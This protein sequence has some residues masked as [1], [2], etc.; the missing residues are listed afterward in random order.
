MRWTRSRFLRK[1]LEG[2]VLFENEVPLSASS[3][4]TALL[5][6][7]TLVLLTVLSSQGCDCGGRPL[8]EDPQDFEDAGEDGSTPSVDPDASVNPDDGSVL[9]ADGGMAEP[10]AGSGL[11]PDG[12]CPIVTCLGL[13]GPVRDFCT[14]QVLQCGGCGGGLVCDV[15]RH[16]CLQP[17]LNCAELG[18]ECGQV[19]N[20][21]GSRLNC[22]ACPDAG[23]ECNRNSHKCEPCSAPTCADLGYQCGDVWLGCGP[24]S[25]TTNCGTCG[26]D[27]VC[28]SALHICEPNCT[29]NTDAV[30]CAAAGANCGLI[31][32]G[33]GGQASCG[34]CTGGLVCGARGIGN[35]CEL[36][37]YPSEC[38]A[39]NRVCGPLTS[40]CGGA[41]LDCGSCELPEVCG[42]DGRCALPCVPQTCGSAYDGGCGL[43]LDAGCGTAIDCSCAGALVCSTSAPGSTGA[44]VVPS[45]CTQLGATGA[46]G[47]ACS[48]GVSPTFPRGDGTNL[49]C[50]CTGSG[51]C[52]AG[53]SVVS[54]PDAGTCCVNTIACPA[55]ACNTTVTN[56][57][58]GATINCTC[59]TPGTNCNNTAK[60]CEPN[61][62]CGTYGADGGANQPCSIGPSSGFPKG[63]GT[64]L[65]CPCNVGGLCNVPNTTQLATP[66][67]VGKCCVNTAVC[68][69]NECN[70]TKVNTCTG[71]TITCGCTAAGTHCNTSTNTCEANSACT[72]FTNGAA[73]SPCSNGASPSFPRGD[74]TNLTCNCTAAGAGCYSG[75]AVLPNGSPTAGTCCVPNTCPANFCGSITNA[76]TGATIN[77]TCGSG[78]H[79]SGSSCV[80]DLTCASYS[81]TGAT[82]AICSAGPAFSNGATPATLLTCGCSGSGVCSNGTTA[83]TGTGCGTAGNPCPTGTCCTNTVACGNQCNVTLTN[84]CTGASIPCNCAAN[85]YCSS[86]SGAGTCIPYKT[87]ATQ[88]PPANGTANAPCSTSNNTTFSRFP[89][90]A[91]GLTCNCTGGRVCSV[92]SMPPHTAG[93]GEVGACCTNTAVCGSQCNVTLKNT[94]TNADII[95]SC[96]SGN[97][98]NGSNTCVPNNTCSTY[99]ANGA[100]GNICSNA[101]SPSFP[102]G[103]GVNLTCGCSTGVCS[104]GGVLATGGNTGNCCVNTAVCGNQCNVTLTNTCTGAPIVCSCGSGNYCGSSNTCKP[105]ETCGSYGANGSSGQPCSNGASASFPRGDGSN[106]TCSCSG[107]GVCTNGGAVVTGGTAGTCCVNTAVCAPNTCAALTNTCTGAPI[108]CSCSA[109]NH[110]KAG[111]CVA[112]RT[113]TSY[114]ATGAIGAPCSTVATSAFPDGP[115]GVNLTCNCTT[116]SPTQNNACVGSNATTAG[117]C[118]C[119]PQVPANCSEHGLPDRCG[120]TMSAACNPTTQVC[121]QNAC[122]VKPVCPAGNSGDACGTLSACG[123]S[124][125]CGCTQQYMTCGANSPNVCGCKAKTLADC[126]VVGGLPPGQTSPNGC[127]GFVTCPG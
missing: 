88:A 77:C 53:G 30:V 127:G 40:A 114:G 106:L 85:N 20:S 110:C 39:A 18:A 121:Y 11:L 5:G 95:C 126:G 45:G 84:S 109:G 12:G 13:C 8:P 74:G 63:D 123:L 112:D 113:C 124:V 9:L 1:A 70:T 79:C 42:S 118:S 23:Q 98:C 26:V 107:S 65:A 43:A 117:T 3:T 56:A 120:G 82:G 119:T 17:A 34:S 81:A 19:R 57:C 37:E 47:A 125:S 105:L 92:A 69:A 10:D 91:T 54:G 48:N 64:N 24:F 102:R 36:P 59:T 97:Y 32:N 41:P 75:G 76:C 50:P 108:N 73:G 7:V 83:V 46:A 25:N 96:G 38:L 72:A 44:C 55:N 16:V 51:V 67:D 2:D 61:R 4:R 49:A 14:G 80:A 22:G 21:C 60:V 93:A 104:S 101:A 15:V 27:T 122:C 66:G 71:A 28:N 90:D 94:C 111:A 29:P 6:A 31:T 86:T 89:G 87:C 115:A 35:R 33:C 100:S 52:V 68:G 103:D 62:T 78:T 116:T 99:G 58:T